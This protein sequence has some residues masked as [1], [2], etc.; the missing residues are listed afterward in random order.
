MFSQLIFLLHVFTLDVKDPTL[1]NVKSHLQVISLVYEFLEL[2][3]FFSCYVNFLY[4]VLLYY[5]MF[6]ML[7]FKSNAPD[8]KNYKYDGGFI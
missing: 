8:G 6:M 1:A 7:K 4:K 3:D 5:L 2:M